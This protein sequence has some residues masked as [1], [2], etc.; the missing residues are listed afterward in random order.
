[1]NP[2]INY[3]PHCY[4]RLRG[5]EMLFSHHHYRVTFIYSK[6]FSHCA[7]EETK[8]EEKL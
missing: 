3:T 4:K 1:M 6:Y 5:Y 8:M 2:K 7:G